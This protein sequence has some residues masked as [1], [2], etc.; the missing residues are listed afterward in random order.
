LNS[1][2]TASGT[3]ATR[4]S[5]LRSRQAGPGRPSSCGQRPSS[6]TGTEQSTSARRTVAS[7]G[8]S[9][10]SPSKRSTW[11]VGP[12]GRVT[13]GLLVRDLER[14]S[15]ARRRGPALPLDHGR[16][17]HV[18]LARPLLGPPFAALAVSR[19]LRAQQQR[20]TTQGARPPLELKH[21]GADLSPLGRAEARPLCRPGVAGSHCAAMPGHPGARPVAQALPRQLLASPHSP[22]IEL[23]RTL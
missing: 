21:Q 16:V 3:S 22:I 23:H 17:F 8:A 1:A 14:A 6:G 15:R 2:P 11:S 12:G 19:G 13:M 20:R 7:E 10:P 4:S 18:L 9:C 5:S